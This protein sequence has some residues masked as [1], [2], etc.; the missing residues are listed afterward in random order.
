MR[1]IEEANQLFG[2]KK[3]IKPKTDEVETGSSSE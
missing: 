3:K 2:Y 1:K